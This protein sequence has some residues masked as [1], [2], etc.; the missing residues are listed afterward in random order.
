MRRSPPSKKRRKEGARHEAEEKDAV[1]TD[2]A[3]DDANHRFVFNE[4]CFIVS[5]PTLE[6][7]SSLIFL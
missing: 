1:G 2:D 6:H 4:L 7:R 3:S 5:P